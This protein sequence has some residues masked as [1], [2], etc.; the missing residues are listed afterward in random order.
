MRLIDAEKLSEDIMKTLDSAKENGHTDIYNII[1]D[2]FIPMVVS[3]PT[4]EAE[5]VK[6]GHWENGVLGNFRKYEVASTVE[7]EQMKH[8]HWEDF[9]AI[10]DGAVCCSNCHIGTIKTYDFCPHCGAKMDEEINNN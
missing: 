10:C 2:I 3:Q 5:S 8:G 9:S 6:H 1:C 7:V 4:I